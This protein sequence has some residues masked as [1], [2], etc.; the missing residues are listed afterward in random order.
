MDLKKRISSSFLRRPSKVER[1]WVLFFAIALVLSLYSFAFSSP[2]ETL[3]D[4]VVMHNLFSPQRT[5]FSDSKNPLQESKQQEELKWARKYVILR[6]TYCCQNQ[7]WALIEL[8]PGG[9]RFFGVDQ[10]PKR[11]IFKVKKGQH[12]G[13]CVVASI[14]RGEVSFGEECAGLQISLADSPERKKPAPPPAP[15][16]PTKVA[17]TSSQKSSSKSVYTSRQISW[18]NKKTQNKHNTQQK[19]QKTKT[20]SKVSPHSSPKS[21]PNINPF[22]ELLKRIRA[23]QQ[24]QQ[25]SPVPPFLPF[26]KGH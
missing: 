17:R 16:V 9:K 26:K 8:Q 3:N 2:K 15:P 7:C 13:R 18:P 10:L 14:K 19:A 1:L 4:P 22:L 25:V 5:Y 23:K 11:R 24:G 20:I 6:G 21:K 12:L